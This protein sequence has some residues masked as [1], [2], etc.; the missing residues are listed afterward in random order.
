MSTTEE[1]DLRVQFQRVVTRFHYGITLEDT[2]VYTVL[3]MLQ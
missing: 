1:V 2:E 3:I